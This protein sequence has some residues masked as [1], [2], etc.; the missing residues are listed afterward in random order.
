M[1]ILPCLFLALIPFFLLANTPPEK[2]LPLSKAIY[3][4]DYYQAQ[5][6]LWHEKVN[7]EPSNAQAWLN[8]YTAARNANVL[9]QDNTYDLAGIVLQLK[10]LLPQSFE[11]YYL[12]YWQSSQFDRRYDAL[13]K[14]YSLAPEREEI[15][16][17][18]L[19]YYQMVDEAALVPYCQEL[20]DRNLIS[21]GIWE[22]NFNALS[23]VR[24]NGILLTQ[25]ENDTYPAWILQQVK[26]IRTD[27]S[28]V[29]IYDLLSNA[30]YRQSVFQK[31]N[32]PLFQRDVQQ[33][34]DEQLQALL[35]HVS[36]HTSRPL[37]LGVATPSRHRS[38]LDGE[39]YLTGLAFEHSNVYLDNVSVLEHNFKE[40]FLM[41]QLESDLYYQAQPTIVNHMNLNYLPALALLHEMYEGRG[42]AV[43]ADRMKNMAL[44]IAKRAGKEAEI[45]PYFIPK[46][47]YKAPLEIDAYMRVLDK[48]LQAI[49][50]GNYAGAF[51]V[52][53]GEY[54]TFL[55]H[56]QEEGRDNLLDVCQIHPT[57]WRNLLPEVYRDLP[58][59]VLFDECD[60]EDLKA[61]ISNI[62][63]EG[64]VQFCEWL[65]RTYNASDHRRKRFEEVRFYLP[66]EEEWMMAARANSEEHASY[67]WGGFYNQ[68]EKGCYLN[69]FNPYLVSLSQEEAIFGPVEDA[70]S[71]G[72]DGGY[73]TVP[74]DSYFPNDFGLYNMSGNVA[75]MTDVASQTKGGGW[76][77]PSYYT[78][79]GVTNTAELP[80]ANVGFRIFMTVIKE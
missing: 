70:E 13:L 11:A 71:P 51:E 33:S 45:S 67:P 49:G 79:I 47:Q 35:L 68:N 69:N 23:S 26:G 9:A 80:S 8:Y 65:T 20:Y 32:I 73:F 76:Q 10:D 29:N 30:V 46:V 18:M 39:L 43:A 25:A 16:F 52:S 6:A 50:N 42:E 5:T 48:N 36:A 66:S 77:D 61:P 55:A 75:E 27:V 40:V 34:L 56:L 78:Q 58:E 21:N 63:Y 44:T 3:S 19:H 12:T 28:V 1:R 22:W 41:E 31:M 17:D 54:L 59:E 24:E 74:I 53:R 64:A 60:P 72:E 57:D 4:L 38:V 2:V 62:A 15:A 7:Q 14:A 37:H